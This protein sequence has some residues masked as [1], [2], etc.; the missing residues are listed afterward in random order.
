VA[1]TSAAVV[2]NVSPGGW[3]ADLAQTSEHAAPVG[4]RSLKPLD[5]E[6]FRLRHGQLR[7]FRLRLGADAGFDASVSGSGCA[8]YQ[9]DWASSDQRDEFERAMNADQPFV[10]G[11]ALGRWQ[12]LAGQCR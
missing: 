4:Q 12:R 6:A 10:A 11:L 2:A 7:L 8:G 3:A 1:I 9:A 5:L